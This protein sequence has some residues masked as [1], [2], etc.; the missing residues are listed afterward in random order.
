M[1]SPARIP[2]FSAVRR[3]LLAILVLSLL[4]SLAT[5]ETVHRR[6]FVPPADYDEILAERMVRV[7]LDKDPLPP[8]FDWRDEGG[9]TPARN[10]GDCGSCWAFA[11]VG[12][13][14]AKVKIYYGE[15]LNLSEQQIVSCNP[16]GAGC[17]GGW[18]GAAYYVFMHH[19]GILENCMPYEGS[20]NVACRQNEFLEFSDM[21]TWVS[22]P[23]DIDQIKTELLNNGP[24]CTSVDANEAWDGYSGGVIDVPG[25]GTNHLVLIVG[26]DDRMGDDGVWIVKNSWGPGWGEGG[27]GYVAYGSCN[28]GS[29]V[30]SLSYTPPAVSVGVSTP[31]GDGVYDGDDSVTIT[32]VTAN[33]PVDAVD[34]YYGT[35]GACQDIPIAENVPNTGSYEWTLPN[36][37]TDR[38]SMVVFPSEGTQRGFG[39]PDGEFTIVGHQTRYVSAAGA[40]VPPYD[41]PATAANLLND[42]VLAG[43]GRDTIMVAGGDYLESRIG[44]GSPAVIMGGWNEDFTVHDPA[45]HTTRLRGVGGTLGFNS[46]A[47]DHCGVSHVTFHDCTGWNMADPVGGRHGGA[48]VVMESSPVI[49]DCVFLDNRAEPGT[50]PGWGGA[51]MAHQGAPVIRDCS[52]S[53]NVASKGAAVALSQCDGALIERCLFMDGATSDSTSAY[54]GAG[55][56]VAGGTASIV[57]SE[58]RGGGAG[59]GGGL[60]LA[61]GAQVTASGLM[62]AANRAAVGGAGIHVSNAT[63]DLRRSEVRDNTLWAGSGGGL[64][65]AGGELDLR[66]VLLV[67]N[68]AP[69]IG[70]AISAQQL[71]GGALQHCLLRGN[72]SGTGAAAFVVSAASYVLTDNVVVDNTG[73][74]LFAGGT[75]MSADHNL[76]HGNSGGDFISA[77]A[78]HDR[79]VDPLL[80]DAE[81]GDFAPG[82]HSPLVDSG[83][84]LA[85]DDWD[86]GAA[87]RGLHGGADGEP[88]GP[89]RV[90]GLAGALSAGEVSLTWEAVEG[91]ASYTVYRDSAE[92]FVPAP[93]LVCAT[94]TPAT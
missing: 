56:Y 92:V 60:A 38:A 12:E 27:F 40:N 67:G 26:W 8:N 70:G 88:V 83:S 29:G 24:V 11:A 10:Q 82:L 25:Q 61:A 22:I 49:A 36:V 79:M 44:V 6:G 19:G 55:V 89:A 68:T 18:A 66:N 78:A 34:L 50:A 69:S 71:A 73:G 14:E 72:T 17:N 65:M 84:G 91:A 7:P 1:T 94:V 32:W 9:T 4:A 2:I 77:P 41:T 23:N 85:G 31:E 20:D 21:D 54:A 46:G 42:A 39:F 64:E 5:A 62:V 86:G 28:I 13:M 43:S 53:G 58:F 15:S 90:T 93:E 45:A 35:A 80:V 3:L 16:Y 51:I 30:T 76:A 37:S 87:D 57:D 52:F 74:G 63:L 48:I 75:G 81:G 47:G 33:E 59:R